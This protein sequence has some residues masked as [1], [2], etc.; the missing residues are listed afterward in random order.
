[1]TE[2]MLILLSGCC[3]REQPRQREAAGGA[4]C[5][6]GLNGCKIL[7]T[8]LF[9]LFLGIA[10]LYGGGEGRRPEFSQ[11]LWSVPAGD[12]RTGMCLP[13]LAPA[14]IEGGLRGSSALPRQ[15][16]WRRWAR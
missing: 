3:L 13:V 7:Y 5:F 6:C 16:V 11:S 8:G 12:H 1:M 14:W 4:Q 15:P 2:E 9:A 10:W